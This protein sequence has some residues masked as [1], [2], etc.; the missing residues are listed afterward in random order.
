MREDSQICLIDLIDCN[1]NFVEIRADKYPYMTSFL[2]RLVRIYILYIY[3]TMYKLFL[4]MEH[5]PIQHGDNFSG[6]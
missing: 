5:L 6:G 2:T 3:I 1:L 4:T